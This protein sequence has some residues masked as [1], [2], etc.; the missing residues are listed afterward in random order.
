MN[1]VLLVVDSLRA[2]S[3]NGSG[4]LAPSTPFLRKLD[5]ETIRFTRAY[6]TEC[7]TLPAHCSMFTGLLPSQHGAHFHSMAYTNAAPTIAELLS[8]AGVDTE[9]VTRNFVFDGTIPGIVRGFRRHTL[10]LSSAGHLNPFALLLGLTKP[11]F[12]R[13][14]RSTGFFHPLHGYDRTF[15]ATFARAM[16]P[17]DRLSLDHTLERME[18]HRRNGTKYFLF[19]NLYDVHAPYPPTE[20]SI[21]RSFGSLSGLVENVTFPYFIS[22]LGAH[23]YLKPGFRLSEGGRRLLLGRYHTSIELMDAKLEDFYR[24]AERSGLL[25]DT[26]LIITSDHG[27]AFGDHGLYLHDASVYETHLHVPLWVHWPGRSPESVDD[28]V[29]T[30]DLFG[31]I[32]GA[33]LGDGT[34]GTILDPDYRRQHPIALAEHFH[35]RHA[36]SIDPRYQQNITAAIGGTHKV[37]RRKEGLIAYD[38]AKDPEETAPQPT[39]VKSITSEWSRQGLAAQSIEAATAHLGSWRVT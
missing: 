1:V 33:G 26:V 34:A 7:W 37:I 39:S 31:L 13:H 23:T 2:C 3:L 29:S 32:R 20:K 4:T 38:V 5:H 11:R 10:L 21:L 25:D 19:A 12:R 9:V 28:V 35:Y 14:I 15:L 24:S 17:A 22:R 27:E 18:T 8:A 36:R 30:R 16:M 6:A